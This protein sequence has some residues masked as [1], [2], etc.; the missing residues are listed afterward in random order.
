MAGEPSGRQAVIHRRPARS[1]GV[2]LGDSRGDGH[3]I[4]DDAHDDDV[5]ARLETPVIRFVSGVSRNVVVCPSGVTVVRAF[6]ETATTWPVRWISIGA[7]AA[8]VRACGA[9]SLGAESTEPK[10]H[11]VTAA[12]PRA[13]INAARPA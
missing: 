4:V 12:T 2:A 3:T 9:E 7:S 11:P 5:L 13:D 1:D 10:V 8:A 6:S